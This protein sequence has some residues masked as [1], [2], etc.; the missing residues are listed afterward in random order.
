MEMKRQIYEQYQLIVT[1]LI[2]AQSD[3]LIN[4]INEI[5]L[6]LFYCSR[7]VSIGIAIYMNDLDP[8]G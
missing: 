8:I 7:N 2:P 3:R 5:E 4:T 1:L 6:I